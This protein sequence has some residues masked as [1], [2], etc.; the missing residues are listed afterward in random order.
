MRRFRNFD[1]EIVT[2]IRDATKFYKAEEYHQDYYTK[3]DIKYYRL[4]SGRDE[5]LDKI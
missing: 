5:F 2:P 4:R 1:K 3:S